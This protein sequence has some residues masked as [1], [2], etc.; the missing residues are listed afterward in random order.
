MH[1]MLRFLYICICVQNCE[2]SLSL[3]I[4]NLKWEEKR[5]EK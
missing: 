2:T 4:R 5:K 3:K 1:F